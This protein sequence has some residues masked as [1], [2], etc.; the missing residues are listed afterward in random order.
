MFPK[1]AIIAA[2]LDKSIMRMFVYIFKFLSGKIKFKSE[3]DMLQIRKINSLSIGYWE[4]MGSII[5]GF[6]SCS[7]FF[8]PDA[9]NTYDWLLFM[10]LYDTKPSETD[11]LNLS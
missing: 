6:K 7:F 9:Q 5:N 1:V 11:E 4:T 2:M 3:S 8:S 10:D